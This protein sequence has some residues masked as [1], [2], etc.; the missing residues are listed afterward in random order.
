MTV[1]YLGHFITKNDIT[2]DAEKVKI[3]QAW[4]QLARCAWSVTSSTALVITAGSYDHTMRSQHHQ[5]SFSSGSPF[6]GRIMTFESL[7]MTLTSMPVHLLT[8]FT[9]PFTMD[10]DASS[11]EFGAILHQGGKLIAFFSHAISSHHAKLAAYEH[12]LICLIK[13]ICH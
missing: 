12:K 8:D 5:L 7:K 13:A 3:V 9:K 2:M 6:A 11:S 4:Q 10:Y 1:A